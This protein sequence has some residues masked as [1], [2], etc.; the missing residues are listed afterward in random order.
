[1]TCDEKWIDFDNPKR[2]YH[3][4]DSGEPT[5]STPKCNLHCNKV[6]LCIWWDI[7]GVLHYEL[8]KPGQTITADRYHQQL[9]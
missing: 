9:L 1:M 6:M 3:W 7:K 2:K 4:I 8:L 5:I